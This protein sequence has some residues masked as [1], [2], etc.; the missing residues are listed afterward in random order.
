MLKKVPDL[1][2]K[3]SI[4]LLSTTGKI[5]TLPCKI[6]EDGSIVTEPMTKTATIIGWMLK[7]L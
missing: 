1:T 7:N 3:I 5:I 6:R 2:P 4:H